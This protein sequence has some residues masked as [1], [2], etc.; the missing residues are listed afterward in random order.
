MFIAGEMGVGKTYIG[1]QAIVNYVHDNNTF[2]IIFSP[3]TV[4]KK[5]HKVLQDA[6]DTYHY[7]I[8]IKELK[9]NNMFV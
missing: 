3:T 9:R 7:D 2:G 8:Q 1:T 6:I 4:V 5:W